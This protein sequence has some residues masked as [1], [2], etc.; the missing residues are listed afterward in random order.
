MTG[1]GKLIKSSGGI[2]IGDFINGEFHGYG[3]YVAPDRTIYEGE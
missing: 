3:K 2:Y 1:K